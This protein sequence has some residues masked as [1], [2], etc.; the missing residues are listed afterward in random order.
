MERMSFVPGHT[1]REAIENANGRI[2]A[3]R[4]DAI[5]FANEFVLNCPNGSQPLLYQTFLTMLNDGDELDIRFNIR[6]PT[7]TEEEDPAGELIGHSW[8]TLKNFATGSEKLLWEVGRRT[9]PLSDADV[10]K[11]FNAYRCSLATH[12][13]IPV[14]QPVPISPPAHQAQTSTFSLAP[15][16]RP[17]TPVPAARAISRALSPSNLYFASNNMFYFVDLSMVAPSRPEFASTPVH[18]SRP[19]PAMDALI[20]AAFVCVAI[21]APPLVFAVV[22]DGSALGVMPESYKRVS[23]A[24]APEC[25][26]TERE[27]VIVG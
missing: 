4:D 14:P 2:I 11:A 7:A 27:I 19:M 12:Q 6:E 18:L 5:R 9:Q 16:A 3:R 23:Y 17:L 8:A 1:A 25:R 15:T 24:L 13:G 10:A 22:Q 20:L 21:G 26:P